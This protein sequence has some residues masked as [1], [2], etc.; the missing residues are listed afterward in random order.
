MTGVENQERMIWGTE[1]EGTKTLGAKLID[2][3]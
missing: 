1:G 2:Q 3:V